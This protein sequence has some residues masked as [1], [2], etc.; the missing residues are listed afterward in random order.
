MIKVK[1]LHPDAKLPQRVNWSDAGADLSCVEP[2]TLAPGERKLVSTGLS[3][4]IPEGYYGRIAPR[5]GLG[6]KHGVDVMAGVAD[7]LYRGEY[8]VLLVNLGDAEIA[9]QA[10][11]RIA[12]LIIEKIG[13]FSFKWAEEL[14]DTSRGDKGFGSSGN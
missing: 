13:L 10:G 5:S 4:E 12:Q 11:D 14:S 2:F 6:F 7:S 1:K 8:K 3:I 9:F